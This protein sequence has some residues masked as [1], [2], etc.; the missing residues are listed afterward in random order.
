MGCWWKQSL[1]HMLNGEIDGGHHAGNGDAFH[2][3][4]G[5]TF[6]GEQIAQ[7]NAVFVEKV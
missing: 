2:I 1:T 5:D 6:M 3:R 7:E 4:G